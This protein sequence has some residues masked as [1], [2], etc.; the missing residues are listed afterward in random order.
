MKRR[1]QAID[2]KWIIG[3]RIETFSVISVDPKAVTNDELFG[4]MHRQTREWRD[5]LFSTIMRD[6]ANMTS[7]GVH[8]L[9]FAK[10]EP[11]LFYSSQ[12]DRARR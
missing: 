3:T 10:A 7:D 11:L 4:Y 12:V 6:L 2:R 8:F 5:G 9:S 1:P